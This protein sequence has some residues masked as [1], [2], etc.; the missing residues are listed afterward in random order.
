M[1]ADIKSLIKISK[2]LHELCTMIE[3]CKI[4]N[5]DIQDILKLKPDFMETLSILVDAAKGHEIEFID[6]PEVEVEEEIT[7]VNEEEEEE[8]VDEVIEVA[9][10]KPKPKK[11]RPHARHLT[12]KEIDTLLKGIVS[13][14]GMHRIE[15][16]NHLDKQYPSFGK[17]R[18]DDLLSGRTFT[19]KTNGLI[20]VDKNSIIHINKN[21]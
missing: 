9:V 20:E 3:E 11:K 14:D 21:A 18:I 17:R 8:I 4:T 13:I 6:G 10:E 7:D 12:E 15:A 5:D 1:T 19:D 2:S 16:R